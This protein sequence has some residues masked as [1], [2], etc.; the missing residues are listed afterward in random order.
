M[1]LGRALVL[2]LFALPALGAAGCDRAPSAT[3]LPEWKPADHDQ[4]MTGGGT[5][6][7]QQAPPP[8]S[9][10]GAP[11]AAVSPVD[12]A[13]Q[14]ACATCHGMGGHGDG[15]SGPMVNAPD[16]TRADFQD[17]ASDDDIAAVI[18]NGKNKMPKFGLSDPVVKGLVAKIR[19]LRG[20]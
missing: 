10:G 7:G 16:L 18:A 5:A 3:G 6:N 20:R 17:K 1:K 13:W 11:R 9:S 15:P 14:Q 12:V 2:V 4:E 8:K 19:S